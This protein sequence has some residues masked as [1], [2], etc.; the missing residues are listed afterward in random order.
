[1][2]TTQAFFWTSRWQKGEREA[3]EDIARGRVTRFSRA[4]A[5]FAELDRRRKKK[6]LFVDLSG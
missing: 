1:M 6:W 2:T 4:N 3:A 5:M